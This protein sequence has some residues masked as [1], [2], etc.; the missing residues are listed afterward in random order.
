MLLQIF[1]SWSDTDALIIQSITLRD[2]QPL[3]LVSIS[4]ANILKTFA[5]ALVLLRTPPKDNCRFRGL[6][7]SST[8]VWH[9]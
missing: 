3:N 1:F 4:F 9:G 8:F 2:K 6:N 7:P 5:Y